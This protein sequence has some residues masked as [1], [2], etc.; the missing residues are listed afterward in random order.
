MIIIIIIVSVC[1]KCGFSLSMILNLFSKAWS[2]HETMW[3]YT[4]FLLNKSVCLK[5]LDPTRL[6]QR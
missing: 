4:S 1:A 3:F 6:I 5:F 2:Y